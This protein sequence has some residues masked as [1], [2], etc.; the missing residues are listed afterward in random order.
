VLDAGAYGMAMASNYNGQPRPAEVVVT[1]GEALL[2]RRRETWEDLLAWES[3]PARRLTVGG[4]AGGGASI[5]VHGLP[6]AMG[7][8]RSSA[9]TTL[10]GLG[11]GSPGADPY[12]H[13]RG[14]SGRLE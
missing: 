7:L 3:G 2:T 13:L 5:A 4:P 10:P 9:P 14:A 8:M 12:D 1:G 6:D 11:G